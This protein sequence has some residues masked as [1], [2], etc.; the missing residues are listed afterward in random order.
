MLVNFARAS[1]GSHSRSF[2]FLSVLLLLSFF[3]V[4]V[5]FLYS[6]MFEMSGTSM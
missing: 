1:V 3:F 4:V 6:S 2:L 5:L